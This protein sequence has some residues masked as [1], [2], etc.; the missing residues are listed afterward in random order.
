MLGILS[1]HT[2]LF[3]TEIW[4]SLGKNHRRLLSPPDWFI[5]SVS[6]LAYLNP[7]VATTAARQTKKGG[8][9]RNA[10]IGENIFRRIQGK[11]FVKQSSGRRLGK[12]GM[13]TIK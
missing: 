2:Y 4:P 13:E 3:F 5:R 8:H 12:D 10:G 6:Q 1:G 7:D 9:G 11:I